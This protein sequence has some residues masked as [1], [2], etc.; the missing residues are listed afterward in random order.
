MYAIV[1]VF[2]VSQDTKKKTHT[3]SETK[4][5]AADIKHYLYTCLLKLYTTLSHS[6]LPELLPPPQALVE[7]I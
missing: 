3:L 2:A 6:S 1:V 4:P 7:V 5:A